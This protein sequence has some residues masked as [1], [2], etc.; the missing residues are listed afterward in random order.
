MESLVGQKGTTIE[1]SGTKNKEHKAG[2]VEVLGEKVDK[3]ESGMEPE[4]L[5]R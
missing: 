5:G 4:E 1:V 2:E 3:R